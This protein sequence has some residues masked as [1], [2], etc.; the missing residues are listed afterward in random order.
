MSREH[1]GHTES[2]FSAYDFSNLVHCASNA[3]CNFQIDVHNSAQGHL[4]TNAG[5]G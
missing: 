2:Y 1:T 3:A 4:Q 5:Y